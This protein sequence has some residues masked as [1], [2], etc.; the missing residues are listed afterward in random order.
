MDV[1]IFR[2]SDA[3]VR[4]T[5]KRVHDQQKTVFRL[6]R[7]EWLSQEHIAEKKSTSK[8]NLRNHMNSALKYNNCYSMFIP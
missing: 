7:N 2:E 8:N 3:I 5:V 6:S 1:I 4:N